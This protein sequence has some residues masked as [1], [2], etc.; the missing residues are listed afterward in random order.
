MKVKDFNKSALKERIKDRRRRIFDNDL[1][2]YD[3]AKGFG[4]TY[5]FVRY[6]VLE[7]RNSKK[8]KAI[9]EHVESLPLKV[10]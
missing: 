1:N 3:I 2:Y 5:H 10:I 4:V 8:S 6:S 7:Q 9:R